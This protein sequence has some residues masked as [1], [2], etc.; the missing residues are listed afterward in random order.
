MYRI[1]SLFLMKYVNNFLTVISLNSHNSYHVGTRCNFI[2]RGLY[3]SSSE[4]IIASSLSLLQINYLDLKFNICTTYKKQYTYLHC[5]VIARI[6]LNVPLRNKNAD[7][8][9]ILVDIFYLNIIQLLAS[10]YIISITYYVLFI[11]MRFITMLLSFTW[12]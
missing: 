7:I 1:C 12:Q 11:P 3:S 9:V 4:A 8:R 10:S 5:T 6:C 2:S